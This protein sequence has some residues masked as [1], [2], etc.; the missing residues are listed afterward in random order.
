MGIDPVTHKPFSHLM[1]EIATTLAPPQVAHLAEA[2]LGC[3]KDEMLH[4]L[5]KKRIDFS[6]T[7]AVGGYSTPVPPPHAS[8][9][10]ALAGDINGEETIQKIKM[11][12]S[13]AVM[14][15]PN[16]VKGWDSM[17]NGEPDNSNLMCEM[18]TMAID[19]GYRYGDLS[20]YMSGEGSTWSTCTGGGGGG[21][22]A[23]EQH[24]TG[25]RGHLLKGKE[26]DAEK[27]EGVKGGSKED[28]GVFGS[29][30]VLWD[31]T[32]DLMNHIV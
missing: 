10:P 20:A 8:G 2:A 14:Q 13:R 32:E 16:P 23:A 19:Q 18:Y 3:F 12:L 29:E 22:G 21:S 24:E 4:L 11:G 25:S 17:V 5:T 7:C 26:D 30:C 9:E 27:S 1:A 15:E 6:S 31:L 28:A